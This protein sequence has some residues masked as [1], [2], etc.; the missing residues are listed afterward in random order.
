M[1]KDEIPRIGRKMLMQSDMFWELMEISDVLRASYNGFQGKPNVLATG[2]VAQLFGFDI[3][4]RST[5]SVFTQTGVTVKAVGAAST[6]ADRSACIAWHPSVVSR[7]VGAM[8]PYYDA[9]S[10]GNGKP[11]YLGAIFNMDVMLGSAIRRNDLK[12]VV[13]LVQGFVST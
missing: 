2:V 4:I 1:D 13:A 9:G 8:T 10:N 5:V 7:A 6:A 3:M 12:G 11:E